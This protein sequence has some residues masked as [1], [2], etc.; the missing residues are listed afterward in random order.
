M[1]KVARLHDEEAANLL[2]GFGIRAVGDDDFAVFVSQRAGGGS[3][4]QRVACVKV[5]AGTQ[6][7][8]VGRAGVDQGVA[9]G[10][11]QRFK[12]AGRNVAETYEFHG[13][14]FPSQDSRSAE[15]EIDNPSPL[16]GQLFRSTVPCGLFTHSL[17]Y[18]PAK[19]M[20]T[21]TP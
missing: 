20:D 6:R 10:V 17:A 13:V 8:V 11:G 15:D 5:A 9:F 3:R 1:I 16:D 7:V 21:P 19:A 12:L 2:L 14:L 18:I 4:L